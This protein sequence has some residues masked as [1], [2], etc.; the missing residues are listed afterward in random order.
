MKET[1]CA[2]SI[3]RD[4]APYL[5]EFIELHR[6]VGVEKFYLYQNNSSDDYLAV[7]Q[8]YID[9]GIV[10]LVQWPHA[11]PSQLAAY[12]HNIN[13]LRGSD[14]W[15][16]YI[17]IDE[18]LFSPVFDTVPEALESIRQNVSRSAFGISWVVF[19]NSGRPYY[20]PEPVIERFVWRPYTSNPIN[21]HIKSIIWMDQEVEVGRDPHL[22]APAGGTFNELGEPI[23]TPLAKHTSSFL[24]LNHYAT[25]S[26]EELAIKLARG[27][28]D[29]GEIRKWEE[30]AEYQA[31]EVL[32]TNIQK[33]L[34]ELKQR[35]RNRTEIVNV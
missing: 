25:K 6:I 15:V 2:C 12:Q 22:F 33:F 18:F 17:D 32:D 20:S 29:T 13:R 27:R 14:V 26:D 10:D 5:K 28:A 21:Q 11:A 30:F 3:F 34:P 9:K 16:A 31:Q 19:G 8:P 7:L 35:L 23:Y 1:V 24:R 4:E